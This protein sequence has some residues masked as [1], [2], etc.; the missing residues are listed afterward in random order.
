[1]DDR[2]IPRLSFFLKDPERVCQFLR[3]MPRFFERHRVRS[4]NLEALHLESSDTHD[5]E[6][7]YYFRLTRQLDAEAIRDLEHLLSIHAFTVRTDAFPLDHDTQSLP[8]FIERTFSLTAD[9]NRTIRR[10]DLLVAVYDQSRFAEIFES[11]PKS[12]RQTCRIRFLT[13]DPSGA[14]D[15]PKSFFTL[16]G[17]SPDVHWDLWLESVNRRQLSDER[18]AA[19]LFYR[20]PSRQSRSDYF[21]EYGWAHPLDDLPELHDH[22]TADWILI[23]HK[24]PAAT[25]NGLAT[26]VE[27]IAI[28]RG[29]FEVENVY[30]EPSM[31]SFDFQLPASVARIELSTMEPSRTV[32]LRPRLRRLLRDRST[33]LDALDQQIQLARSRLFL[34][35]RE[36]AILLNRKQ[37]RF[38]FLLRFHQ[39][40]PGRGEE[41]S[42]PPGLVRFLDVC[43]RRL[44]EFLYGY[45]SDSQAGESS[46]VILTREPVFADE[47]YLSL[48]DERSTSMNIGS[49]SH[50]GFSSTTITSFCRP[51]TIPAFWRD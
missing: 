7:G 14:V 47:L 16:D 4:E 18:H 2:S 51:P 50:S 36:R 45:V 38:R 1:M 12:P 24:G 37:R 48:A 25:R 33:R 11:A 23:G 26:P 21:V 20:I 22:P 49:E 5:L 44:D 8:H 34:M 40:E 29:Q 27:W 31:H 9:M 39:R 17:A 28:E 41:V 35:E 10:R 15:W 19:R 32:L 3:L 13:G 46:H 42:L 30:T 43:G 6:P